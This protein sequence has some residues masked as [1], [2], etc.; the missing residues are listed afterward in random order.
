M[1]LRSRLLSAAAVVA[2][3]APLAAAFVPAAV[4]AAA[5]DTY[6]TFQTPSK[7]IGCA[8]SRFDGER[9]QL[10]CDVAVVDHPAARPKSCDLDY[11]SAFGLSPTGRG[12]RL[13]VGDTVRDPKAKV[14]AYGRTRHLGPFTCT[15]RASG[16]RCVNGRG[17][18]FELSRQTQKLF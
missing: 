12:E 14:L 15:S 4:V 6:V 7:K 10:R 1:T 5:K 11:G 3:A 9:P 2:A 8:Y 16:L 17:H 13:C 18:G